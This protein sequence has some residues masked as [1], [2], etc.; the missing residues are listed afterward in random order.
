MS[1]A[2]SADYGWLE[3]G[4][5]GLT[6]AY[7]LTFLRGLSPE[8]VLEALGAEPTGTVVGVEPLHDAAFE[9]WERHHGDRVHVA[10]TAVGDWTV[11]VE[12]NGYL[13]TFEEVMMPLSAG[14]GR[15]VSHFRNVNA[16]DHFNLWD[17]GEHRLHFEP[18]FAHHREGPDAEALTG[19][20]A[21]AGFDLA[22]DGGYEAHTEAAW[23]LAERLTGVRVTPEMIVSAVFHTGVA[24]DR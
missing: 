24:P 19:E 7:C 22:E 12:V 5:A 21:A 15:V 20:M 18:L 9:V 4:D 23:A 16:V 8:A 14:G 3:E 13:G 2:T 11:L 10:A 6:E 17:D 1:D